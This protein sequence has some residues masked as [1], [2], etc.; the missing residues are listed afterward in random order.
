MTNEDI[1][2]EVDAFFDTVL[3]CQIH[4]DDR[5]QMKRK[6]ETLCR[7]V[8]SKAH[9]EDA[10]AVC[11]VCAGGDAPTLRN[12]LWMHDGE[13]VCPAGDIHDLKSALEPV[14]A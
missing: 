3:S 8:V 6:I 4:P 2:A 5:D 11:R 7:G 13:G 9:E 14:P 12:G 10:R 1:R